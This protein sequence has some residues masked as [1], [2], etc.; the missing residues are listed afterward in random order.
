MRLSLSRIIGYGSMTS[1][2][3]E[4]ATAAAARRLSRR[5]NN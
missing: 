5:Q 4:A 2:T 1:F 3:G